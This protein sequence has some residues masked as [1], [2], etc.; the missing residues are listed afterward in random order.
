MTYNLRQFFFP[1]RRKIWVGES[2]GSDKN[3]I[4]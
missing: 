2:I 3:N 4:N 1:K